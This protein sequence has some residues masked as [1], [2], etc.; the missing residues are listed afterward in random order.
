MARATTAASG[1]PSPETGSSARPSPPT[2]PPR[3]SASSSSQSPGRRRKRRTAA[4]LFRFD[5]SFGRRFVAGVDE[6]GRG[7]LAG[8]LLAAGV[9]IDLERIGA[10]E[11]R[12]LAHL[13]DSKQKSPEEREALYPH[14]IR[15]A[16][17]VS[18]A[19]RSVRAI[20][21]RGLHVSNLGALADCMRAIAADVEDATRLVDGFRLS[22]CELEHE[23]IVDGDARSAAIAAASVIAKVTRDRYM[24]RVAALYPRWNFAGNVGYSTPEHRDAIL[25]HGISP[26]H[27]RSFASIAYSQLELGADLRPAQAAREEGSASPSGGA[28]GD[29]EDKSR[30]QAAAPDGAALPPLER[31]ANVID[32][33][34]AIAAEADPDDVE[35]VAGDA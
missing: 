3:K 6:A 29:R 1:D 26:L 12:A 32:I 5:H 13:D 15:A 21:S 20:D 28:A 11:R 14:V 7:S 27:R 16:A 8:P 35:A 34:E 30:L 33:R 23:A 24:H 25:E 4:R 18:V 17:C 9:L 31:V 2:G 22:A 19:V 10:R